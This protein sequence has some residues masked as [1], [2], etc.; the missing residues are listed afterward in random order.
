MPNTCRAWA[1]LALACSKVRVGKSFWAV[2]EIIASKGRVSGGILASVVASVMT[3]EAI[4]AAFSTEER[5][6]EADRLKV[7]PERPRA[8]ALDELLRFS[9]LCFFFA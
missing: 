6:L 9:I 2:P 5:G 3:N 4:R 8:G 1:M 7:A